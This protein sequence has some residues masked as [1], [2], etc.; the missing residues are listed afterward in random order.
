MRG[1]AG[2]CAVKRFE[3]TDLTKLHR[4]AAVMNVVRQCDEGARD[5]II[6]TMLQ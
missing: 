5:P 3:I 6:A 2:R 1:V 4:W